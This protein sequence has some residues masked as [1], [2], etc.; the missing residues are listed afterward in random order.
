MIFIKIIKWFQQNKYKFP[1]K[2]LK[3]IYKYQVGNNLENG[4]NKI[5]HQL[6]IN[7]FVYLWFLTQDKQKNYI[8]KGDY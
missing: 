4:I 7:N 3:I 2:E 5:H 1:K 6:T 8:I